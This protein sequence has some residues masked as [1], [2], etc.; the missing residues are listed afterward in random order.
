MNKKLFIVLVLLLAGKVQSKIN[1]LNTDNRL[2]FQFD[3]DGDPPP[4]EDPPPPAPIN[5]WIPFMIVGGIL[6][7]AAKYSPN[8]LKSK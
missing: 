1:H 7:V 8:R 2:V 3:D 6:F 4:T 5:D